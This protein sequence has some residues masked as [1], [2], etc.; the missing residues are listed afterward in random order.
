VKLASLLVAVAFVALPGHAATVYRWVDENGV[1]HITTEKPPAGTKA[2][3]LDLPTAKQSPS[4][5]AGRSGS[6]SSQAK[7]ATV[8]P[9][10]AAER[11]EVLDSL[12]NRECVVA[13]EALDRKTSAAEPTSATEIKRLQQTV[14]ANCSSNPDQRQEQENLAAR[15]RV[16]NGSTCTEARSKLSAMLDGS[17]EAAQGAVRE[18][19]KFVDEYCTPP[20]R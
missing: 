4:S 20:V 8:S 10:L 5:T 9:V 18:Q 19:Q 14:D 11:A 6:T 7:A 1:I 3:K 2:E 17:T 15:L 12:K 16:A 13:L